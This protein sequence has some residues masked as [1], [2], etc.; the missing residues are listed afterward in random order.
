M[1]KQPFFLRP[2][3]EGGGFCL[4]ITFQQSSVSDVHHTLLFK[5]AERSLLRKGL[6]L[7][8]K[9]CFECGDLRHLRIIWHCISFLIDLIDPCFSAHGPGLDGE[10]RH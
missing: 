4:L 1:L 3:W 7:C 10:S 6:F 9:Q 8:S 2:H 5:K